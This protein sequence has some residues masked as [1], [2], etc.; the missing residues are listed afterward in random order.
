MTTP[1]H[2][3]HRF[4]PILPASPSSPRAASFSWIGSYY[5]SF[6]A[7]YRSLPQASMSPAL[8]RACNDNPAGVRRTSLP[9]EGSCNGVGAVLSC[10]GTYGLADATTCS[11]QYPVKPDPVE[12]R[13]WHH[14]TDSRH[15]F[16]RVEPHESHAISPGIFQFVAQLV[17]IPRLA[18][19]RPL[20]TPGRRAAC[21]ACVPPRRRGQTRRTPRHASVKHCPR[22]PAR[23]HTRAGPGVP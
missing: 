17:A 9:N 21:D 23:T 16:V 10:G 8:R 2:E 13:R 3:R 12:P 5:C 4:S 15:Q 14:R 11:R 20:I 1:N 19:C 7:T 18:G 22:Q 6:T